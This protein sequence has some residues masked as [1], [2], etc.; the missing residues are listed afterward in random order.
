[1]PT[2]DVD[3]FIE[4]TR[5]YLDEKG[6]AGLLEDNQVIL[7]GLPALSA[8][9]YYETHWRFHVEVLRVEIKRIGEQ[10]GVAIAENMQSEEWTGVSA[11]TIPPDA[12]RRFRWSAWV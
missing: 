7:Q 11:L 4:L 8:S 5:Q 6:D 1:M 10:T 12:W 9:V 2:P 3:T